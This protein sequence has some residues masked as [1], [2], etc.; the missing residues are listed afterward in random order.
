MGHKH[1]STYRAV[2]VGVA[3][4]VWRSQGSEAADEVQLDI[5]LRIETLSAN[6]PTPQVGIVVSDLADADKQVSTVLLRGLQNLGLL[7]E[8]P[9]LDLHKFLLPGQEWRSSVLELSPSWIVEHNEFA[10]ASA[11][12]LGLIYAVQYTGRYQYATSVLRIVLAIALFQRSALGPLRK[13]STAY[14]SL[15]FA[16]KL[17]RSIMSQ[18]YAGKRKP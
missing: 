15:F 10:G 2:G 13:A 8:S 12:P 18:L 1:E 16:D 6:S 17:E 4:V 7:I 9:A 11:L 14:S 5:P 3:F